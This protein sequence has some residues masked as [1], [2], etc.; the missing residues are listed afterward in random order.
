MA[1]LR[2]AS[3][4]PHARPRRGLAIAA[5]VGLLGLSL[6]SA[7]QD[8]AEEPSLDET[9]R[10]QLER[11]RA[12]MTA[13]LHLQANDLL[14]EL[15]FAWREAPPFA[16]PTAVVLADVIAP[17][18]FGSGLEAL[19]ENH[20]AQLLLKNPET[21]VQLSH[22]PPC[23]AL[24]VHSDAQG[25]VISRAVDQPEALARLRGESGAEHALFLDFEAEGTA[26]VLRARVTKLEPRLPIVY[27]RTLSTK[28]QGGALL[29]S[30]SPLLSSAEAR[31]QYLAVLEQRGPFTI[32]VRLSLATFAPSN[33]GQFQISLPVPWLSVG[34]EYAITSAR[35]WTGS[36]SIGGTFI[37]TVQTG[38]IVQARVARLLTGTEMSLTHPNLYGFVGTGLAVLTGSTAEILND[39]PAGDLGPLASWLS[40]QLGLEL[41]VSR[42]IGAA[43]YVESM[44]TLW[45][46]DFVGNF[47]NDGPLG[48]LQ[49]NSV[50]VEATF[51][52]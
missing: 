3:P 37:P 8:R 24:L 1:A 40:L 2:T 44:P 25:T 51:A 22:C 5:F 32:P 13:Q 31:D 49:V 48:F 34:V 18:G 38:A 30:P 12:E 10:A 45:N 23:G 50:G 41:R 11:L 14:D 42:R 17:L 4:R 43:V 28:T 33:D 19:L 21:N 39:T 46:H 7:A 52:F 29:R 35:A 26:L 47:L 27:A 15:V 36:L 20:L 16:T 6:P 9:R